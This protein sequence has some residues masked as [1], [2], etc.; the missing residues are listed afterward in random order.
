MLLRLLILRGVSDLVGAEGGEA[1]VYDPATGAS[2]WVSRTPLPT[3]GYDQN[4]NIA[5]APDG[6]PCAYQLKGAPGGKISL[7]QW[8]A[9]INTQVFDLV[10]QAI[11]HRSLRSRRSHRSYL[12]TNGQIDEEVS[13]AIQALN[14]G[15]SQ[16]REKGVEVP[17]D[18]V[19]L[20]RLLDA[21]EEM[22]MQ[23]DTRE[24]LSEEAVHTQAI[25][26][27]AAQRAAGH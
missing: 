9:E 12:V 10:T 18:L 14:E 24:N 27:R 4:P 6:V 11:N 5:I 13:A 23:P 20:L 16:A 25:M 7:A 26:K 21:L 3:S 22:C 19:V 17:S 15:F 2:R 8:R 1:Y